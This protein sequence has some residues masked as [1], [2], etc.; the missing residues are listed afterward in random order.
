[1]NNKTTIIYIILFFLLGITSFFILHHTKH[2]SHPTVKNTINSFVLNA[3]LT[4]YN[5]YGQINAVIASPKVIH[6]QTSE[7]TYLI[8]PTIVAYTEKNRT[9]WHIRADLAISNRTNTKIILRGHVVVHQLPTKLHTEETITTSE[10]TVFPKE[11]RAV[12]KKF[13][14]IKRPGTIITGTGF[15]ANLKTGQY[16]LHS[17][18][19]A[20]YDVEEAKRKTE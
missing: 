8:K 5:R 14:T 20:V 6:Y 9:P 10:L 4:D 3:T 13:V 19:N 1:M 2:T 7:E 15:V 12:S 18:S 11:S 17:Q 16:E